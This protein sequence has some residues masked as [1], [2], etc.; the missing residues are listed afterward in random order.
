MNHEI[1]ESAILWCKN[2][3][4][5]LNSCYKNIVFDK[6]SGKSELDKGVKIIIHSCSIDITVNKY[7]HLGTKVHRYKN[8]DNAMA[9]TN[10]L[11]SPW[12]NIWY[13]YSR[14]GKQLPRAPMLP[15]NYTGW[16]DWDFVFCQ[17]KTF[18]FKKILF[19][20]R[21]TRNIKKTRRCHSISS[22]YKHKK[23]SMQM[24]CWDSSPQ[25]TF[26]LNLH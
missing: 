6:T 18:F 14:G 21:H 17:L 23:V 9:I 2:S 15:L 10:R 16:D 3:I 13:H 26:P 5:S 22:F 20:C 1:T 7:S 11:S 8:W 24:V 12:V 19:I 25:T 4:Q